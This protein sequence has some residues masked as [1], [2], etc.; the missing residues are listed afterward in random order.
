[1][2]GQEIKRIRRTE[3]KQTPQPDPNWDQTQP[4]PVKPVQ[5][6]DIRP[7]RTQQEGQEASSQAESAISSTVGSLISLNVSCRSERPDDRGGSES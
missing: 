4:G 3:E 6:Y 2:T 1:M 5:V 7:D